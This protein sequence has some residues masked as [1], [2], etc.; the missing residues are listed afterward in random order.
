MLRLFVTDRLWGAALES[1]RPL[2]CTAAAYSATVS[3]GASA[4]ALAETTAIALAK[5]SAATGSTHRCSSRSSNLRYSQ[6]YSE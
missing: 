6:G 4:S 1:L 5:P 2:T 3:V